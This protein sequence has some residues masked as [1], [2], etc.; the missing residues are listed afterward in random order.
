MMKL[1]NRISKFIGRRATYP[2]VAQFTELTTYNKYSNL[3]K[4][5]YKLKKYRVKVAITH[6]LVYYMLG[7][8]K[9]DGTM[10]NYDEAY[11]SKKEMKQRG[12]QGMVSMSFG[13]TQKLESVAD[14]YL[15][16]PIF[17][18]H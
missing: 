17:G 5:L 14:F 12:P 13:G 7:F 18:K 9:I 8:N 6:R 11:L 4:L 10:K 2:I 15:H 16:A 1:L 3:D